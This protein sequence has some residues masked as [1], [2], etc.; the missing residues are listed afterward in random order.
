MGKFKFTSAK[1]N[2]G[3]RLFKYHDTIE[4]AKKLSGAK[5]EMLANRE[6]SVDGCRGIVEYNDLYIKLRIIGG[7][8]IISGERL[9][10]P[11][12]EKPLITVTGII[13]NIELCVR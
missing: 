6:I 5:I 4:E 10:I 12:F 8:L 2:K 3:L 7:L 11:I 1:K 13:N 9:Q